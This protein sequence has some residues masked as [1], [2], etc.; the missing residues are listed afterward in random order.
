MNEQR[1]I[2]LLSNMVLECENN[3]AYDDANNFDSY[4]E[5]HGE[6]IKLG[7]LTE[8]EYQEIMNKRASYSYIFFVSLN[9][10]SKI[11]TWSYDTFDAIEAEWWS[12]Y[13]GL[14][15][16]DDEL[17]YSSINGNAIHCATFEDLAYALGLV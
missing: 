13:C 6:F 10:D 14:P 9:C 2:E 1:T 15:M 3:Y 11:M 17:V 8:E 4:D 7:W 16:M 12:E 5:A